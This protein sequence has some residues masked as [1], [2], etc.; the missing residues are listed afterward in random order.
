MHA[1]AQEIFDYLPISQNEAEAKYIDH[2]WKSFTTLCNCQEEPA[3]PF[4]IM[5]FHLL[6]MYAVQ[7]KILRIAKRQKLH[8]DL[9]FTMESLRSGEEGLLNPVSPFEIALLKE[10]KIIDL[11]KLVKLDD[12]KVKKIKKLISNRNDNL[13]HA[14]GGIETDP[15]GKIEEYLESLRSLQSYLLTSNEE[16][17]YE[18]SQEL[19]Q[20]D[21][22]K[23]FV[24]TR[25]LDSYLCPVDFDDG[26][27]NK[28]FLIIEK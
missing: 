4:A 19:T 18:W 27:L 11:L 22:L 23:E 6:F 24:E 3:K 20:E 9:A 2:L 26:T 16:I 7:C 14:K 5:P 1:E 10:T 12:Q 25:L 8:Y 15:E 17:A 28:K 21:D 13:A